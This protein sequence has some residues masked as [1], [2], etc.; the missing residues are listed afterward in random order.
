MIIKEI[1]IDGF[2]IYNDF[3]IDGLKQG[4]NILLG[5]N[6]AGKTTLLKF[7]RYTL[8]G[9]PRLREQRM[10]P[11]KG[12]AHGG[13][14]K[15]LLESGD[16]ILVDRRGGGGISLFFSG[17][18]SGNESDLFQLLGNPSPSLYNNVYAF[19]LDELV[20][21]SSLNESGVEDK[22]FSVGLG[23]GN[24]SLAEMETEINSHTGSIYKSSGKNKV[25]PLI[26]RSI[27]EKRSE[28]AAK[29]G[30]LPRREELTG[31]L[32][33]LREEAAG[34]EKKTREKASEKNR[35]ENYLKCHDSVVRYVNAEKELEKLPGIQDYPDNGMQKMELLLDR[36]RELTEKLEGLKEGTGLEKGV[37][38]LEELAG[39]VHV[40][41]E[42]LA[43]SGKVEYLRN[44]LNVYINALRDFKR[45]SVEL[46]RLGDRLREKLNSISTDWTEDNI[47]R[48]R[49]T[50]IHKAAIRSF[51][52]ELDEIKKKRIEAEAHEAMLRSRQSGLNAK[53]IAAVMSVVLLVSSFP[54]FYYSLHVLGVAFVI[55]AVTI[56][57]GRKFIVRESPVLPAEKEV[58]AP[59]E[60]E[61]SIMD[62]YRKYLADKL[63]LPG[64]LP[65]D[66]AEDLLAEIDKSADLLRQIKAMELI[67]RD[68]RKPLISEFESVTHSLASLV[69]GLQKP[70]TDNTEIVAGRI[71][72][73]FNDAT[74]KSRKRSDYEKELKRKQRE[75][76]NTG[77]KISET[78]VQIRSLLDSAGAGDEEDFRKKYL[79]NS[80]VKDLVSERNNAVQTIESIMGLGMLDEVVSKFMN[81]GKEQTEAEFMEVKAAVEDTGQKARD[82]RSSIG[83]IAN[84]I[85]RTEEESDM[86]DALTGLE[87]EKQ[88]LR[89]ALQE[90]LSGRLA[91]HLL[92]EVRTKYEKEKQPA[93]INNAAG[94]FSSVTGGRY[95]RL[96]VS[97]DTREVQ[98]YDKT[99]SFKTTGQL[100]RGAREQLLLSLRLGFIEEYEKRAEPLPVVADEVLV[101]FDPDRAARMASVFHSF[102][103]KRQMLVFTCHPQT[104][105]LF[106]EKNINLIRL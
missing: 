46:K 75:L 56:F 57:T 5:N 19:T 37:A 104:V 47:A 68:E 81:D 61:R 58:E 67:Q 90:W 17:R 35:L 64:I 12:G 92:S 30:L 6:E 76:E 14:I 51:K 103:A 99:G 85:K 72:A 82:V 100:S 31:Q 54:A 83:E 41:S 38:E 98:V 79:Q 8:F 24:I 16:E 53:G 1:H 84:E 95:N 52:S 25:I 89:N 105:K 80:R 59:G 55:A 11:A 101:N 50:D 66:A 94:Y 21:L 49:G 18:E 73:E 42:L 29:K 23:L 3:S 33:R 87:T 9:Y 60:R 96:H 71:L 2:G 77:K 13:K 32:E 69:T 97:M 36:K 48:L 10:L 63:E 74:E 15:A 22:I 86:A 102:A 39:S 88:R 28:I 4:I 62:S 78:V 40:N 70:E 45:D 20:S 43:E 93:V 44:N 27:G 65:P 34:L 91:L 7:L 106:G 26:L